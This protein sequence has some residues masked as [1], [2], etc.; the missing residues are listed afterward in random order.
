MTT[1]LHLGVMVVPY[2]GPELKTVQQHYNAMKRGRPLTASSAGP[3]DTGMVAEWLENR[4]G[5]MTAFFGM[6][7]QEIADA[8]VNSLLGAAESVMMGAPPTVDPF[9]AMSSDVKTLFSKFLESKEIEGLGL[10]GVP[11]E[12]ALRGVSHRFKRPYVKRSPRP[13]FI[14][15]GTY[16]TAFR[17][18]ADG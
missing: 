13:S 15:T 11:T 7:G 17:A 18:W 6:H 16:E 14:D 4:Y 10:P 2:A 3:V 8:L 1:T 12:A 5:V 9:G